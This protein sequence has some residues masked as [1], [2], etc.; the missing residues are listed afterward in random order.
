MKCNSCLHKKIC[1][2]YNYFVTN[3]LDIVDL[4]CDDYEQKLQ[5]TQAINLGQGTLNVVQPR[6]QRFN[7][8]EAELKS[9]AKLYPEVFE[10]D[11]QSH[12]AVEP[13]QIQKVECERCKSMVPSTEIENCDTCKRPVCQDCQVK[14]IEDGNIKIY[15][16]SC[17]S[18]TPD[19]ELDEN[20]KPIIIYN[21]EEEDPWDIEAFESKEEKPEEEKAE[22]KIQEEAKEDKEKD[23][24]KEKNSR[25]TIKKSKK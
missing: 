4:D 12:F 24:T 14:T 15:C 21:K 13:V 25:G 23:G 19:P 7:P 22:E 17:W 10:E 18:N 9:Y 16:E 1:R 20:G 8:L 3:F 6:P 5:K 11:E 2:H